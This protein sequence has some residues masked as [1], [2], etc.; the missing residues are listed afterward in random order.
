MNDLPVPQ[1][2]AAALLGQIERIMHSPDADV[3]KAQAVIEMYNRER[4]RQQLDQ[5]NRAMNELQ[6]EIFSVKTTGR[7]PTFRNAYPK[8]DDLIREARPYYTKHGFSIRFGTTMQK[9]QAEPVPDKWQRVVLIISHIGGH[10]EEHAMDGPPDISRND[11]VPRSPVQSIGS[12]NTYL[13]RYLLQ[14]SLNL[15]AGIDDDGEGG[16][17]SPLTPEQMDDIKKLI[18]E[19]GLTTN[20][21]SNILR[22]Y[23]GATSLDDI[24]A[25]DFAKVCNTFSNIKKHKEEEVG[26][27]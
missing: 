3:S 13:R 1:D 23:G 21:V 4:D 26:Q 9:T 16:G 6:T 8:L 27:N 19:S 14:M 17:L 18:A 22:T 7:N 20:E 24:K 2:Q 12:T 11:R 5:F 10:W 15:I 25:R